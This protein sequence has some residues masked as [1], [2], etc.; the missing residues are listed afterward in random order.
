MLFVNIKTNV[1]PLNRG[2]SANISK[3]LMKHMNVPVN[4]IKEK[5][6]SHTGYRAPTTKTTVVKGKSIPLQTWTG[7][8]GSRSLRLPEFKTI[9][10]RRWSGCYRYAPATFTPRKYSWYS[11]LLEAESTPGS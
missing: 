9:G 3:P 11:F 4:R 10:T 2:A 7:P 6:N 1:I 5:Q 8:E